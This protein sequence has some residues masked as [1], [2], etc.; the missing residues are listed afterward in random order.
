MENEHY[1]ALCRS[2]V[3][4]TQPPPTSHSSSVLKSL[5]LPRSTPFT[6]GSRQDCVRV[7]RW[8]QRIETIWQ[9]Q[10]KTPPY[11]PHPF[12]GSSHSPTVVSTFPRWFRARG[13]PCPSLSDSGTN[14]HF[15]YFIL[16]IDRKMPLYSIHL[17]LGTHINNCS[18]GNIGKAKLLLL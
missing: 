13:G 4:R 14:T 5:S 9:Q 11:I 18:N 12:E 8:M 16:L 3:L 15:V 1:F 6:M 2:S 17:A 10:Q 7:L